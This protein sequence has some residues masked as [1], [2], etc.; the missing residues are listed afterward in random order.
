[1]Y[2]RHR[3]KSTRGRGFSP[4]SSSPQRNACRGRDGLLRPFRGVVVRNQPAATVI[5]IDVGEASGRGGR[6]RPVSEGVETGV[7]GGIAA[8]AD[9]ALVDF[10]ARFILEKM[11]E[12][13]ANGGV[14]DQRPV[15]DG[16]KQDAIRRVEV[17]DLVRVPGLQRIVPV[18]KQPGD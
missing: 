4:G 12:I 9:R 10:S 13:A 7:K 16:G 11:Y 3:G 6:A 18:H 2:R 1:M 8:D 5:L 14:A 17:D 15:L